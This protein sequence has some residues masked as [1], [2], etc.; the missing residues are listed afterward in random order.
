MII[1]SLQRKQLQDLKAHRAVS[2]L[3]YNSYFPHKLGFPPQRYDILH[4]R[5]EETLPGV[6][7]PPPCKTVHQHMFDGLL[8]VH[9]ILVLYLGIQDLILNIVVLVRQF[10]GKT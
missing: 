2:P 4:R 9:C 7:H 10:L 1:S 6:V 3:H 5:V 8:R